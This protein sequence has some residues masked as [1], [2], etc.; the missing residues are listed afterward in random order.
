MKET[1]TDELEITEDAEH[2]TAVVNFINCG[3][4]Q[5]DPE[6]DA[7]CDLCNNVISK[8]KDLS[9]KNIVQPETVGRAINNGSI[10]PSLKP[11]AVMRKNCSLRTS[12]RFYCKAKLLAR[13]A[14]HA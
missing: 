7:I 1:W 12:K 14:I 11:C 8:F 10:H 9:D 13:C 3:K 2:K 6:K 4:I 5:V